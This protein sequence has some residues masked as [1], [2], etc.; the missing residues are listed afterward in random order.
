MADTFEHIWD[1]IM[2]IIFFFSFMGLL[3][4]P[5]SAQVQWTQVSETGEVQSVKALSATEWIILERDTLKRTIDAGG[6]WTPIQM[7]DTLAENAK[8]LW[9]WAENGVGILWHSSSG[10]QGD[11]SSCTLA[12][13]ADAGISWD[14][15]S[16]VMPDQRAGIYNITLLSDSVFICYIDGQLFR[17]T[18][19]GTTFNESPHRRST[20][21][22][23][24]LG[25]SYGWAV[26]GKRG[27]VTYDGGLTWEEQQFPYS[28]E[29]FHI[30][31]NGIAVSQDSQGFLLTNPYETEWR[32]VPRPSD[33]SHLV[34]PRPVL[35]AFAV[36]DSM[37]IWAFPWF[38]HLQ[39]TFLYLTKD[40]GAHWS[41]ESMT[42]VSWA[43]RLDA[44][45][46]LIQAG[47]LYLL[48]VPR[49]RRL[50][51]RAVNYSTFSTPMIKL[52]WSDPSS[53]RIS[54]YRVER[55]TADSMWVELS[56]PPLPPDQFHLDSV[57][58]TKDP[59]AYRYCLTMYTD[60]GDTL[61]AMSDSV[62]VQMGLFVDVLEAILPDL[63]EVNELTYEHWRRT[64]TTHGI[65]SDT[66][67]T[68]VYTFH[69]SRMLSRWETEHPLRKV[70]IH[71]SGETDTTWVRIL[72]Y[73]DSLRSFRYFDETSHL[74]GYS[75]LPYERSVE[76]SESNLYSFAGLVPNRTLGLGYSDPLSFHTQYS[77]GG[78][79]G[80]NFRFVCKPLTGVISEMT[81][82]R[83]PSSAGW[84]THRL[85][86]L[87]MVNPVSDMGIPVESIELSPAYPNPF[88]ESASIDFSIHRSS[89]VR[90]TVHDMLGRNVAT[91]TENFYSPGRY[92]VNF[93]A[94]NLPAGAYICRLQSGSE[95]M[96]R[97]LIRA[98]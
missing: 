86:L 20:P 72:E 91:L 56:D 34:L 31:L 90:L 6:H 87:S 60:A 21:L 32:T 75:G 24:F 66:L 81:G 1:R 8:V 69:P 53:G 58:A 83:E 10:T 43:R 37:D 42:E 41:S 5:L 38:Y 92:T 85:R 64:E 65:I 45:H 11:S 61:T 54:E 9:D 29:S 97:I 4:I 48:T 74:F 17:S 50:E 3:A 70:V 26:T 39:K 36:L 15:R 89:Q 88:H 28:L 84:T 98:K 52:D 2:R 93:H 40:G 55:S 76:G 57:A 59:Q 51:L 46:A 35:R 33:V 13:T 68:V 7:P 16:Y 27:A 62:S 23:E 79:A 30:E 12:F 80:W 67:V 71:P 78:S 25:S 18:D 44:E 95:V 47:G 22:I 63:S 49:Q 19:R 73:S 94:E 82:G 96:T 77:I 14:I